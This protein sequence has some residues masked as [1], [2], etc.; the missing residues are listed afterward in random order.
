MDYT[1]QSSKAGWE[2][3]EKAG[4]A[5]SSSPSSEEPEPEECCSRGV[6]QSQKLA[7]EL[8][9]SDRWMGV[10]KQACLP[11]KGVVYTS[12]TAWG[13]CQSV[14]TSCTQSTLLAVPVLPW[15]P[16]AA[17]YLHPCCCRGARGVAQHQHHVHSG[18]C[19][20]SEPFQVV[21]LMNA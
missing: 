11:C 21:F 6:H 9:L 5:Q 19:S 4:R 13:G 3:S 8:T 17:S 20:R 15:P 18:T 16:R 1:G 14:F 12:K 7:W 10:T 2:R